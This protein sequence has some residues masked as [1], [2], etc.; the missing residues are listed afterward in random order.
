MRGLPAELGVADQP[1]FFCGISQIAAGGDTLFTRACRDAGWLQR[2]FLPQ[3]R[4]EYLAASGAGGPDFTPAQQ[5]AAGELL[6][7]RHVIQERVVSHAPDRSERFHDVSLELARVG[8]LLICLV[9]EEP[10]GGAKETRRLIELGRRRGRP[11]VELRLG[12]DPERREPVL[13]RYWHGRDEFRPPTLPAA[14]QAATPPA[15]TPGG[16]PEIEAYNLALRE[17]SSAQANWERR[18]FK[19]AA[20][21][22]IVVHV[23]A[24]LCATIA[25]RLHTGIIPWLLGAELLFLATGF[26]VHQSLH[27]TH[28]LERWALFRL[29]AEVARSITAIGRFHVYLEHLFALPFP[30]VLRP[31]LRTINVLHLHSNAVGRDGPWQSER[32][33]Y[34]TNRLDDGTTESQLPYNEATHR[35]ARLWLRAARWVFVGSTVGAFAATLLKLLTLGRWLPVEHEAAEIL[36]SVMGALAIVLP[37]VAV[38]ALSLVGAFDLDAR[39]HTS[40]EMLEFLKPQRALLA[41]ASTRRE[42]SQLLI[43]TESRLL[44]ETVNWYARRSFLGVA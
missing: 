43:E 13:S 4:D 12:I 1:Y 10:E 27:R 42:Y 22:I 15:A 34:V 8:D 5:A 18:L 16:V 23:L 14:L 38:A 20:V 3:H 44:G 9:P 28:S 37:V 39:L 40:G 35:A 30:V 21:W 17:L 19:R 32:D 36:M 2:I 11:V 41:A 25:L 6:A 7:A 26:F 24:T 33:A 31:I 29:V